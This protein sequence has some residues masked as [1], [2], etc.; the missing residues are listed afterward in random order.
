MAPSLA[1]LRG[2]D[3]TAPST[4]TTAVAHVLSVVVAIFAFASGVIHLAVI[5]HH[6]H[7]ATIVVG[8]AVIAGAQ[9]W[10]AVQM[11]TRPSRRAQQLGMLLHLAIVSTWL[12]SRSVG[13]AIVPG[14]EDPSPVGLADA[15][16]TALSTMV[17][18]ALLTTA[19]FD[20]R[21]SDDLVSLRASRGIVASIALG[22]L[23]ATLPAALAPHDHAR[24][25]HPRTAEPAPE[26]DR[27][28]GVDGQDDHAHDHGGG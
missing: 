5:R 13:L 26:G 18:V 21:S 9:A 12:L 17:I 23:I 28:P 20:R 7:Y 2:G 10:F 19:R 14:A 16:A 3:G 24:H 4:P 8:F 11:F 6:L 15:I 25:G 27:E 1:P 22:A